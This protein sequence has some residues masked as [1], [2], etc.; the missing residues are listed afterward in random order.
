MTSKLPKQIQ[1][2]PS[3]HIC[4]QLKQ[5]KQ[6]VVDAWEEKGTKPLTRNQVQSSHSKAEIVTLETTRVLVN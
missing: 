2:N 4:W 6:K 3:G 5:E 1:R